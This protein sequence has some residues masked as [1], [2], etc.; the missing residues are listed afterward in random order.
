MFIMKKKFVKIWS[1]ETPQIPN[2]GGSVF[3]RNFKHEPTE[4]DVQIFIKDTKTTCGTIFVHV[5]WQCK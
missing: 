4:E 2:T 3:I 5:S 1:L